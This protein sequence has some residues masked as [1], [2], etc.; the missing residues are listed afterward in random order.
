M[1]KRI[2]EKEIRRQMDKAHALLFAAVEHH[3]KLKLYDKAR[4]AISELAAL[5]GLFEEAAFKTHKRLTK[6][7]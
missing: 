2:G 1:S 4:Q 6:T 7:S 3:D 5:A